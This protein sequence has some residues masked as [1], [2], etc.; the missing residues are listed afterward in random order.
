MANC[1]NSITWQ[2]FLD[3]LWIYESSC[4]KKTSFLKRVLRNFFYKTMDL[5]DNKVI[6]SI[7]IPAWD[8]NFSTQ[9][10]IYKVWWFHWRWSWTQFES[11][12]QHLPWCECD[13]IKVKRLIFNKWIYHLDDWQYRLDSSCDNKVYIKTPCE[14]TNATITYSRWPD[15]LTNHLSSIT[16]KDHLLTWLEYLAE[17]MWASM[18]QDYNNTSVIKGQ[19]DDWLKTLL[20]QQALATEFVNP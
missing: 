13:W 6:E 17:E 9:K 18:N 10:P 12:H 15:A 14:I 19:F 1:N 7:S 4:S 16:I 20:E 11:V 8:A 2:E 3:S 5:D